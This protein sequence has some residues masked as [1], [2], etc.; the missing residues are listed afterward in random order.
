MKVL[1]CA[2]ALS[3]A[4]SAQTFSGSAQLDQAIR[5]AI[6]RGEIPGAVLVVGRNGQVIH[7]QAYGNRALLP[8]IEPMTEDTIF[9]LASLTK[10]VAT[11]SAMMKLF[12]EG[13]IRLNDPVTNYI[14]EFQGGHSTITIRNLMTH[15]S[16]LPP[17]VSMKPAWS[18]YDSGIHVAAETK[19]IAAPG[20]RFIYSDINFILCGEIVHRVTGQSL[21]DYTREKIFLP[22]GMNETRF[23]PPAREVARIAPTERIANA[24]GPLRG[25]VHDP[26]SQNMGGVAGHAGLFS[27]ADDLSRFAQMMLNRGEL[28]GVRLF[29]PLTVEKF[30][31]PQSPPDQPVLRGLGWDIDSPYS[32]TRGELFP[33]GSYGHTGFT[34]TSLWIDPATG[35]YVILLTNSVH[36][37]V[38]RPITPLRSRVATIAAASLDVLPPAVHLTGYNETLSL[39]GVAREVARNGDVLT[40]LDVL[41]RE[42][43]ARFQGKRLGL[44]T[45][46]T[47]IDRAGRRNVDLM[48]QAG[49]SLVALYSPEHG[50][51]GTEDHE[52]I[53]NSKDAATGIPVFSLYMGENRRPTPA[54]LE[55]VDV[56]VFD[57]QDVG[58]RFYTYISTMGNAME[59]AA[60]RGIE[61]YVLDRPNPLT[62]TRVEGPVLDQGLTSFVGWYPLPLRHGMTI[63][64]LA[65]LFNA[66]KKIGAKLTV[67]E[68]KGWERGDWFDSTRLPWVNPSP[69]MRSLTAALLY[70]GIAML[71]YSRNYSVGRGTDSPFEWIGA[72]FINGPELAAYL[73]KRMVPG[74]RAYPVT[75]HPSA[76]NLAGENI[77]GIRLIVTDRDVFNSSTLGIELAAALQQLY[78]GKIDLAANQR[79]IGSQA[80]IASI[81]RG[82][83]PRKIV[84][85]QQDAL[86][87]F[88]KVREKYLIYGATRVAAVKPPARKATA[89]PRQKP[90]K[91]VAVKPER[92]ATLTRGAGWPLGFAGS[93]SALGAAAFVLVRRQRVATA[94]V[95]QQPASGE[96]PCAKSAAA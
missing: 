59:E 17:S 58:A 66:E 32:G 25:L 24:P 16:G 40:G 6:K 81:L 83:E 85:D 71:E 49:V 44:I 93:F 23:Q 57:I 90:V 62:G 20:Q 96:P 79:L 14:P 48:L 18:G 45:N 31:T 60:K 21:A 15:F 26:T 54:M 86:A 47:G 78:P 9:D 91:A 46:H 27:T 41:A 11:T 67:V 52:Q 13:Q 38:R 77:Q 75:F 22:L 28:D 34:G 39:A 63:G 82:D 12:E 33:V 69:N 94:T 76:S 53:A 37:M 4:A 80:L 29:S 50:I 19:P 56:L 64:E 42:N 68:M 74:V 84:Q 89:K 30:T 61:F 70:P 95:Q 8:A 65:R 35:M 43:F 73:N 72:E 2:A 7:R 3:F 92:T 55:G 5:S 1:L 87:E 36:P 51:A 10:V 88:L